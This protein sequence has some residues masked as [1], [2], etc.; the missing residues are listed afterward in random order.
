[1]NHE[2]EQEAHELKLKHI[3]ERKIAEFKGMMKTLKHNSRMKSVKKT[4][5]CVPE[6]NGSLDTIH[7]WKYKINNQWF[8]GYIAPLLMKH[9]LHINF[10]CCQGISSVAYILNYIHKRHDE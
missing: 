7:P 10:E 8:P 5:Q 3:L 2:Y 1:M 9:R 6:Y 4:V